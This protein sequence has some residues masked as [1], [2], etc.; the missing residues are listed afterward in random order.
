MSVFTARTEI[1]IEADRFILNGVPTL[2]GRVHGGTSVAGLLLNSRMANATFDDDNPLTRPL[3]AYPDTGEWDAERNTDEFVA[4]LPAYAAFG[5]NCVDINLQGAA[6]L[7]YYRNT[8]SAIEAILTEVRRHTPDATQAAV[9]AGVAGTQSQ[10]WA[11][12]GFDATGSPKPAH[13]GR[14]A[15]II[16]AADALGMAVCL[17]VFY[18]GQDERLVDETAVCRAVDETVRWLL[19]RGYSNVILEINNECD[20]PRYEHEILC[21]PRVHEL[22]EQVRDTTLDGRRL[23]VGTSFTRHQLPP[24]RVVSASDFI[25]LHGN[26]MDDPREVGERVDAVRALAQYRGQPVMFNEDDHFDFGAEIS[27]ATVALAHRAGWG[28]FDPASGAGGSLA[29]GDYRNGYQNP[30]INWSATS[31]PRKQAFFDFVAAVSGATH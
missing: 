20:I 16:E 24:N 11:S 28:Y 30:P 31:T 8:P 18:F 4:M 19:T 6:P 23:L 15:R 27:N 25:L 2:E 26:G 7:G 17:G 12:S 21:P 14:A 29:F 5:L 22:I 9:W 13:L 1:S 3:W 10:P